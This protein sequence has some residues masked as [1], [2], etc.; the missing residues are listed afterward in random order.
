MQCGIPHCARQGS[1]I[2][3][4][5]K[6]IVW[7]YDMLAPGTSKR[8]KP[9]QTA[10]EAGRNYHLL[11]PHPISLHCSFSSSISTSPHGVTDSC[12]ISLPPLGHTYTPW[13]AAWPRRTVSLWRMKE[14]MR[15]SFSW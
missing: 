11:L 8:E 2:P 10:K 3:P 15:C 12:S 14:S 13:A 1:P 9:K 7:S 6:R 5:K 4:K